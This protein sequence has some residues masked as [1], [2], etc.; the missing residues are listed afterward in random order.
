MNSSHLV[1]AR[2]TTR[3]ITD[4]S[5]REALGCVGLSGQCRSVRTSPQLDHYVSAYFGTD[6]HS[7]I[8]P[9]FRLGSRRPRVRISP[10][11]PR[12]PGVKNLPRPV[13]GSHLPTARRWP[14]WGDRRAFTDYEGAIIDLI[15]TKKSAGM[16]RPRLRYDDCP[17][18]FFRRA[19][20]AGL[21]ARQEP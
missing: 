6:R 15:V 13:S 12:L 8:H 2:W 5:I 1:L 21:C 10:S 16:A 18:C 3:C 19:R 20:P 11:R 9:L 17:P 7:P 14:N 4:V